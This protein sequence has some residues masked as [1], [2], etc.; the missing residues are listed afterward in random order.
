MGYREDCEKA[1]IKLSTF[2][3]RIYLLGWSIEKALSVPAGNYR[4][5]KNGDKSQRSGHGESVPT[6]GQCNVSVPGPVSHFS[7]I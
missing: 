7:E 5:K 1:G 4:R 3:S 6:M 2:R